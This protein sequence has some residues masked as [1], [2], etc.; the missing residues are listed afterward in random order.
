MDKNVHWLI[1]FF[2]RYRITQDNYWLSLDCLVSWYSIVRYVTGLNIFYTS[3]ELPRE[4]QA[5][6]KPFD[7]NLLST[8]AAIREIGR[9]HSAI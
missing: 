2:N 1:Y 9:C 7:V 6:R 5:G 4:S 3:K 8:V